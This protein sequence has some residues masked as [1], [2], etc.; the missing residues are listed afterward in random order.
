MTQLQLVLSKGY[1]FKILNCNA[2]IVTLRLRDN[3]LNQSKLSTAISR[4]ITAS[5]MAESWTKWEFSLRE[6]YSDF[7]ATLEESNIR[8]HYSDISNAEQPADDM[9]STE[10][11]NKTN[12]DIEEKV[13]LVLDSLEKGEN[14]N[15]VDLSG[16]SDKSL[17][18]IF[19][20]VQERL[21][22]VGFVN[23][24]QSVSELNDDRILHISFECVILKKVLFCSELIT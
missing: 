23:F 13:W 4:D 20:K 9:E 21:N 6:K 8:K 24:C 1:L 22:E 12:R 17:R 10:N 16:E 2:Y 3:F 19:S 18:D 11:L 5:T 15:Q 7:I 14:F